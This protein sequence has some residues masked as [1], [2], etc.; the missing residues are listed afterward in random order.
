MRFDK[1]LTG[2][3][4]AKFGDVRVNDSITVGFCGRLKWLIKRLPT[5]AV[6]ASLA[7]SVIALHNKRRRVVGNEA[8]NAASNTF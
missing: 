3:A 1:F 4:G 5:E 2:C 8:L 6:I 7:A